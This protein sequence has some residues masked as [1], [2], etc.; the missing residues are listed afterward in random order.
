MPFVNGMFAARV[1][2]WAVVPRYVRSKK[3]T[4]PV[5]TG[6]SESRFVT[7]AVNVR[8]WPTTMLLKSGADEYTLTATLL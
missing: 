2:V 3:V 1:L 7:T 4:V 6:P 8:L 5:G